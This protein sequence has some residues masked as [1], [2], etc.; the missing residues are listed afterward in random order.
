[1]SMSSDPPP[2]TPNRGGS[3]AMMVFG[4]ILLFPGACT[5]FYIVGFAMEGNWI[6]FKE[7]IG[8]MIVTVWGVCL[9]I[10]LAGILMVR[11]ARAGRAREP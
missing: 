3:T 8:A 4:L 10:S 7:P 11:A 6:S 9:L 5:L 1:M 2:A